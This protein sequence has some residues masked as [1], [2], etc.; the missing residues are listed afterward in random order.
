MKDVLLKELV[1]LDL[2]IFVSKWIIERTPHI[3]NDD[4]IKY[5]GWRRMFADKIGVDPCAVV[6]TGTSSVGLSL[7]P[8]KNFRAFTDKSDIDIAIIS[9]FHFEVAWRYLKNMGSDRYKLGKQAYRSFEEHKT[10]LIYDGTIATDKIL[11]YLP[12]GKEWIRAL[13]D[14][15]GEDPTEGRD[16]KARVYRDFDSLRGYHV[17]GAKYLRAKVLEQ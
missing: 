13:S 2:S 3:F 9:S 17:R 12:F 8:D 14:M 6:F 4:F 7:N 1:G 10:R 11:E 5:I 15:A 16:I